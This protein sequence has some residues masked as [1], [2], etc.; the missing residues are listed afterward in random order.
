MM[1]YLGSRPG[2]HRAACQGRLRRRRAARRARRWHIESRSA[3]ATMVTDLWIIGAFVKETDATEHCHEHL[4][5][6]AVQMQR[7][8]PLHAFSRRRLVPARRAPARVRC[9]FV[10]NGPRGLPGPALLRREV[11]EGTPIGN[12]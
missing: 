8:V 10:W 12:G 3:S 2:W 6:G 1:E 7:A 4:A 9:P 11:V 5:D